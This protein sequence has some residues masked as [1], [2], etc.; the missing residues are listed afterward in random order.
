MTAAFDQ[1]VMGLDAGTP[2]LLAS[3]S[4]PDAIRVLLIEDGVIDRGFL[5]NDLSKQGFAV[6]KVASLAGAPDATRYADV[7]VL[8]CDR[9]NMSSIDLLGKLPRLG[10]T[11]LSFC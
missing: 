1:V 8:H 11:S 10:L 3:V 4:E 5:A 9:A 7:I 6:R 2:V